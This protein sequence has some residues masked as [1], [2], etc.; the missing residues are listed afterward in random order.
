MCSSLCCARAVGRAR[1]LLVVNRRNLGREQCTNRVP[2]D[3]GRCASDSA[4]PIT[5]GLVMHELD[6]LKDEFNSKSVP[7]QL[8]STRQVSSATLK[9]RWE[10]LKHWPSP[11]FNFKWK[12]EPAEPK[13]PNPNHTTHEPK[14]ITKNIRD[15]DA[16]RSSD[17]GCR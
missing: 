5:D 10:E 15:A 8:I 1:L 16:A 7:Y 11:K 2:I 4:N 14:K 3:N 9:I 12:T 13:S 17:R 6:V